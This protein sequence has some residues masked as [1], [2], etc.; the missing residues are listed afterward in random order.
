MT[1]INLKQKIYPSSDI[2]FT[3]FQ[4]NKTPNMNSS[5]QIESFDTNIDHFDCLNRY[6]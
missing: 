6:P 1:K 3:N 2:V 5:H 4:G